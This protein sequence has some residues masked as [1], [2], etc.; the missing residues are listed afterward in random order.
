MK[1]YYAICLTLWVATVQAQDFYALE[2]VQTIEVTFSESNWDQLMDNAYASESGYILAQSVTINGSTFDSVGVK[3]KGNSSYNPNQVKNP[4][5]IELDTYK[6]HEYDGYTDIKLANGAKDPSMIRDVLAYQIIRQYMDAPLAN[7]ANLYVN[8]ELIGLYA[9]T[10]S[11][12][13]KFMQSRF[14]SKDN[15]RIKC[16]PPDGAGPQSNDFPNL[17]YLGPDSTAYV[18]AYEVQ[19]DYGWQELI[20]LCDTLANHEDDIERILDVNRTLWMLAFDNVIVNLDSYIGAFS[21][22]YYLYRSMHGQFLPVIWDLN[23]SFGVFSQTGTRNLNNTVSKQQMSHL[24]HENDTDFPLVQKLL[25]NPTY[26]R[27]YLAHMKTILL[28]NFNNGTYYEKGLALQNTIGNAVLADN[29]KLYSYDNF[30]NNLTNDIAGGGGG[31]PGGGGGGNSAPGIRNLMDARSSYL[32]GLTDFSAI[33]PTIS[34]VTTSNHRPQINEQIFISASISDANHAYLGFRD[35]ENTAPF[36][37]LEMHDDG[38]HGDGAANDGIYGV[39]LDI[40]DFRT[41]YY[42]YAEND[43]IGMFSPR[44]AEFE[45]YTL[46][47]ISNPSTDSI[48]INEFMASNDS[49]IA[50]QDGEYED[51][52]ELYNA[53]TQRVDL[54][55]FY[56]TD[57]PSEPTQWSFPQETFIE[58]DSYLIIWADEDDD[59]EGL[60]ANFKLSASGEAILLLNPA[61]TTVVDS[62]TYSDQTTD[63]SFARVPNGIGDFIPTAATFNANNDGATD[64]A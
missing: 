28:E 35:A 25:A 49:T 21:Q 18:D 55:G 56:L 64:C 11:V 16:S 37:K 27:I 51:W 59:Q 2:T 9:N 58:P 7:F 8:G 1:K 57:D 13:K 4:W 19:S 26:K 43:A 17:V 50:D 60:H 5:H 45:F 31:R 40:K 14:G 48:V 30:I 44:R 61:D 24:L 6:D 33:D 20:N 54:G 46:Q 29:N 32:L 12:S 34:D 3:Y 42:I 53:S 52:I 36:S 38:A 63:I 41:E 15:A 62:I 47:A 10:E 23:E 22:N 39:E